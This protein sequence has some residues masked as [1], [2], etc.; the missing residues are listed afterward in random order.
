MLVYPGDGYPRLYGGIAYTFDE[1]IDEP[2]TGQYC[3]IMSFTGGLHPL[4]VIYTDKSGKAFFYNIAHFTLDDTIYEAEEEDFEYH[5][6]TL[7]PKDD[8]MLRNIPPSIRNLVP[9]GS[10]I[11]ALV[12]GNLNRDSYQDAIIVL[13]LK[14]RDEICSICLLAGD[15]NHTFKVVAK[16]SPKPGSLLAAWDTFY[17]IAIKNGYF[18]IEHYGN[19]KWISIVTYEFSEDA[20]TW[21]V[22]REDDTTDYGTVHKYITKYVAD[23]PFEKFEPKE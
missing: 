6:S 8:A 14:G 1:D 4:S 3:A 15:S 18:S 10:E 16:N 23:I 17:G 20:D 5:V 19:K 2:M 9:S 21:L 22:C 11:R 7:H 12:Y 13:S